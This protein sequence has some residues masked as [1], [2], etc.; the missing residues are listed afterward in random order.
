MSR[1][2]WK[3]RAEKYAANYS[4]DKEAYINGFLQ[5]VS[6]SNHNWNYPSKEPELDPYSIGIEFGR[7]VCAM[8]DSNAIFKVDV[9]CDRIRFMIGGREIGGAAISAVLEAE[10]DGRRCQMEFALARDLRHYIAGKR[11][12]RF[13]VS[14]AGFAPTNLEPR[15]NEH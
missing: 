2:Q 10:S 9:A 8:T 11:F 7:N 6:L 3:T 1:E 5:G 14:K 15:E 13:R 4:G 12:N